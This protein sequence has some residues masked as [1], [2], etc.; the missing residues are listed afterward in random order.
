MNISKM[1]WEPKYHNAK[2]KYKIY[3]SKFSPS[4]FIIM[5]FFFQV[6]QTKEFY[7]KLYF[8]QWNIISLLNK[9][10]SKENIC[11]SF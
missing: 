4:C 8:H 1:Y 11:V 9:M 2:F 6:N 7:V 5:F 10:V 3:N